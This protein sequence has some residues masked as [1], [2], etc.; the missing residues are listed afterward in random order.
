[1]TIRLLTPYAQRPFNAITTF[2]ASVEAG[3]I[4]AG[5]ASANLA[6]G[7]RFYAQRPGLALQSK[8]IAVGT[9]SLNFEEQTTVTLPEGQ[10]L[11]ITGGA[12]TVGA[13]SRVGTSDAW[14]IGVGALANIGPYAGIQ[15]ILIT[16][17]TGSLVASVRDAAV[18]A[19]GS[20]AAVVTG[21]GIVGEKVTATL[22]D[23]RVG[24]LQFTRSTKAVPPIKTPIANAVANSVNSLRYTVQPEDG[25]HTIGCDSSNVVSPSNG[26]DIPAVPVMRVAGNRSYINQTSSTSSKQMGGYRT[27]ELGSSGTVI[28][29]EFWNGKVDGYGNVV[30][31]NATYA[32]VGSGGPAIWR[33]QIEYNGVF[34]PVTFGGSLD[35]ITADNA[36][37]VGQATVPYVAGTSFKEHTWQNQTGAG[38]VVH[39][40]TGGSAG[41]P[42]VTSTA[43]KDYLRSGAVTDQTA[44]G[45]WAGAGGNDATG[46]AMG[47]I[48]ISILTTKPAVMYIGTSIGHGEGGTQATVYNSGLMGQQSSDMGIGMINAGVRAD[49]YR[50]F[51][52]SNAVRVASGNSSQVT[53]IVLGAPVN[54]LTSTTPFVRTPTQILADMKATADLFPGKNF[55]A[56]T[57]TP[58]ATTADGQTPIARQ[59]DWI[60]TNN[61]IRNNSYG[62]KV[63][64]IAE[65]MCA[66]GQR[67]SCKWGAAN[68]TK[69]GTHPTD[70]GYQRIRDSGVVNQ[71]LFV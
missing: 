5:K 17:T 7:V 49:S 28:E 25:S 59:Q 14:V 69:E 67:D 29:L 21:S 24:T 70:A 44:T 39:G 18:A 12:G 62:W 64:D 33:S 43:A 1:M 31:A 52:Q 15:D 3:L 2:D 68:L 11:L 65:A 6:G 46:N 53:H 38:F 30:P 23:G 10:V 26:I 42:T 19:G 71:A 34:Y 4:A 60:D 20:V 22:P 37:V 40:G 66:L 50:K 35:G 58:L 8:Q 54:D 55:V 63:C 56:E 9:V 41:A 51:L 47:A 45:N 32:E 61:L 13:A 27:H 16:C 57:M 48:R 36:R